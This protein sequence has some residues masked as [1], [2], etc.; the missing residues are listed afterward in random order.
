MNAGLRREF[1][2][3]EV[4]EAL[5]QMH[6]LKA[7]GPDGMNALFF[8]QYWHIVGPQVIETVLNFLRGGTLPD[9]MNHTFFVLIP[10]KKDPNSM[11]D[12]RPISLCNVTYKLISKVLANRLK[13]FLG[14]VVSENQ[15]AFTPGRLITDNVLVAF[16]IFHY[17]NNSRRGEGHMALKLDMSKAYDRVE[18]D[19]L[20]AALRKLGFDGGWIDRVMACVRSVTFSVLVNGTPSDRFTPKR[21]LR[22]GDPLS[23]YLFI[24]C[25]EALSGLIRRALE[26]RSIHGVRVANRAPIVSHLFFADDSIIFT[27]ATAEEMQTVKS[28]LMT[29]E[30]ASGQAINLSKTTVSFSKCVPQTKRVDLAGILGVCVVEKQDKYLGLPTWVGR[31]KKP[32][33][34]VIREKL[35]RKLQRWKGLFLS[36]AGREVLIKAV[37]QSI[38]TYVMSVFKIPSSFCDEIRS[39]VSRFWWGQ[40]QT[41]RKIHWVAWDKLC[42]PK[43]KGGL[44]F[45]DY[46]LFNQALLGKQAWRL[47]TEKDCLM[48]RV[49]AGKYFPSTC[50][51]KSNLGQNPSFTWRSIWGAREVLERG[52]RR[53]IGRGDT[54][55]IWDDAWISGTITGRVLSPRPGDCRFEK[56]CELIE[57]ESM[58]WNRARLKECFLAFEADRVAS[59]SLSKRRPEDEWFW[60]AERDGIYTVNSAYKL[61]A[62]KDDELT[63]A[64]SS[65]TDN[66]LWGSMWQIDV[67]PRIKSFFWQLCREALPTKARIARRLGLGPSTCPLCLLE[68]ET[69]I[70]LFRDCTWT[71]RVWNEMEM[72]EAGPR[73]NGELRDWLT[74]VWTTMQ[75]EERA[76]FMISCWAV[77]RARNEHVFESTELR[78]DLVTCRI[79]GLMEELAKVKTQDN[80]RGQM[81]HQMRVETGEGWQP[82]PEGVVKINVDA[83]CYQAKRGFGILARNDMGAVVWCSVIQ[84]EG[85]MVVEVA[86]AMAILWALAKA[87]DAGNSRVVVESDCLTVVTALTNNAKGRST[88]FLILDD[89]RCLA[90]CFE[91]IS[92]RHISR[93]FNK[94]AHELAHLKPWVRGC[95]DWIG[96]VPSQILSIVN[97]DRNS[98]IG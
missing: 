31:S 32:V 80:C 17:M 74:E 83:G 90:S 44:G 43:D 38:P 63:D 34:D 85:E 54:T 88:L 82:P 7:P 26:N 46:Q 51:M 11:G 15:S 73:G 25:A 2:G 94:G 92:W 23:P 53:R 93:N 1:T 56:V 35:W 5:E 77:W 65:S 36:K 24:L 71:R 52:L 39:V 79:R 69:D 59:I 75:E 67:L 22:Q 50:F 61:L 6:P 58:R 27:K 96:D 60:A 14:D 40:K 95:R 62:K 16:E 33:S 55:Y 18:W 78:V 10:K 21:G 49:L 3:A 81:T 47:C 37:A 66:W 9:D 8:Q 29:Y 42:T 91:A 45:R 13:V 86:E 57:E 87:R 48:T 98:L 89:I 97:A 64:S 76:R 41:E 68:D 20:E 84:E 30:K 70:H 28:I 19:F 12:F 72:K 4:V